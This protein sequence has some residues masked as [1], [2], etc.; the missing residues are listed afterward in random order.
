MSVFF[1]AIARIASGFTAV[2]SVPALPASKRSPA[3][4]RRNPSAIWLRAE[5]WVHRK[6][7]LGLVTGGDAPRS[8]NL[9]TLLR[10]YRGGD[11]HPPPGTRIVREGPGS[12][13]SLGRSATGS[14]RNPARHR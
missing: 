5:L 12:P 8:R 6:R 2:F 9:A 10:A 13:Y 3:M 11:R 1:S 4:A 14:S 7:T